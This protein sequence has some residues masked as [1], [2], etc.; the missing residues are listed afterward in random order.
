L[1]YREVFLKRGDPAVR[2]IVDYAL[3]T[4]WYRLPV[5]Y[6]ESFDLNAVIAGLNRMYP[7]SPQTVAQHAFVFLDALYEHL[8][9]TLDAEREYANG[10]EFDSIYGKAF[11]INSGAPG[12]R[13]LAHRR[14]ARVVVFVDPVRGFRGFKAR[15]QEGIDFTP[16]Y[17]MVHD[18]EPDADWFLHS[19][20]ELVLCGSPKAPDRRLSQLSL[21]ALMDLIR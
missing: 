18:R 19:S 15:S 7:D 3:E 14:G 2:A 20:K 12:V 1:V 4:D 10:T 11:A 16:I 8:Q 5:E 21:S 6:R 13:D 17:Q 9:L